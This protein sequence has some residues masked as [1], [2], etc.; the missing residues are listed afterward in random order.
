MKVALVYDR[1]NKWGGAERVL[2]SLRKLFPEAPLYTSVY[3]RE[4]AKWAQSFH[5]TTS[6]LQHVPG[7]SSAHEFFPLL[8]PIAFEQF[9]FDE[10]DL[11]ISVTSE[12]AKG[13]VTK[14]Q[15]KHICYC[16]TPTRYLWSGYKQYFPNSLIRFLATP[17]ITYLRTWDTVAAERP[18][19]FVAIS[20][21]VRKRIQTFY[22]RDS[23]VIFPPVVKLPLPTSQ[24]GSQSSGY[25]L[26]VSRLV[27]YKRVDLAIKACNTLSLP[28]VIIGTGSEEKKLKKL[29]GPTVQ[30][31]GKVSDEK[32]A[33]YYSGCQAL[34]FPGEEDFGLT[35]VEAQQFGKPVIA[36]KSGGAVESIVP[37]KTGIFFTVPTPSSLV[38][39]LEAF[40]TQHFEPSACRLQAERFSEKKF[41][42][43]FLKLIETVV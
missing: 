8:M 42:D 30:F 39:A 2:L 22:D 35:I 5:V 12:A 38:K 18:D 32:L 24:V 33:E 6:F 41:H 16:L 9:M 19:R 1:V 31:I 29:A 14:P 13:I 11:V 37:G 15:T 26:I 34:L 21:V 23:S 4:G 7:A 27:P 10:Y 3:H 20:D 43:S 25:F 36:F 28:L 17:A 40:E